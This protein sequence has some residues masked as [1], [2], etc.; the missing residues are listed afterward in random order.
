MEE[1]NKIPQ[2]TGDPTQKKH[3]SRKHRSHHH[4]GKHP[5]QSRPEGGNE[6]ANVT[7]AEQKPASAAKEP[8]QNKGGNGQNNKNNHT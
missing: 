7:A 2:Q 4:G 5:N 3:R 1:Q 6:Q 8:N